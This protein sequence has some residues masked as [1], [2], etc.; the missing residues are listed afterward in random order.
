MANQAR[1][2]KRPRG[3]GNIGEGTK[4]GLHTRFWSSPRHVAEKFNGKRARKRKAILEQQIDHPVQRR[5]E[6]TKGNIGNIPIRQKER[7][8][9]GLLQHM[10]DGIRLTNARIVRKGDLK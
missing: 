3:G 10:K 7:R 5:R 8:Q 2:D 1:W 4:R 6:S 9:I